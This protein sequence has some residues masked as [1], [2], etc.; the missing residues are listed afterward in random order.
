M[1]VH[2]S[3]AGKLSLSVFQ[4]Q[5]FSGV[6]MQRIISSGRAVSDI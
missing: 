4:N 2:G 6:R 1:C 5:S 3:V